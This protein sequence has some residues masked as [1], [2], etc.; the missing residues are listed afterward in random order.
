MQGFVEYIIDEVFR[1][2]APVQCPAVFG[3]CDPLV[4]ELDGPGWYE[5]AGLSTSIVRKS[6]QEV[7]NT[8]IAGGTDAVLIPTFLS[9]SVAYGSLGFDGVLW[10]CLHCVAKDIRIRRKR[11]FVHDEP[12]ADR[13]NRAFLNAVSLPARKRHRISA[14]SGSTFRPKDTRMDPHLIIDWHDA[15]RLLSNYRDAPVAA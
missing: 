2:D 5:A 4:D 6:F 3:P 14:S 13:L 12:S 7:V 10:R 8:W 11:L 1:F 15:S 9:P